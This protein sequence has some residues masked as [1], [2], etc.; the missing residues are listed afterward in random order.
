MHTLPLTKY[1]PITGITASSNT[2]GMLG[3]KL[4]MGIM[5][6]AL[7]VNINIQLHTAIHTQ[8]HAV[9]HT[10][11]SLSRTVGLTERTVSTMHSH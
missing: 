4:I 1:R 9:V 10:R 5:V 2:M 3:S 7:V 8:V 6:N 11:P